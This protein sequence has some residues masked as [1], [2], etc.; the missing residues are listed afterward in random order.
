[1][2]CQFRNTV[3]ANDNN[4]VAEVGRGPKITSVEV[5][6][7]FGSSGAWLQLIGC[8]LHYV[9]PRDLEIKTRGEVRD[10]EIEFLRSYLGSKSN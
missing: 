4:L 6:P 10:K 1:M 7:R 8:A 9:R 2:E 5:G 3:M